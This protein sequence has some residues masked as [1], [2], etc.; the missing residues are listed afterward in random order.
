MLGN[1]FHLAISHLSEGD[2]VTMSILPWLETNPKRP[3]IINFF[4]DKYLLNPFGYTGFIQINIEVLYK[5]L[6]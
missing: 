2:D 5:P 1:S 3:S 4:I 6:F